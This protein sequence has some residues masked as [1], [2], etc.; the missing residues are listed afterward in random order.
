MKSA[1]AIF[2]QVVERPA[3]KLVFMR[4]KKA[5]HYY[6]YCEEQGCDRVDVV[7]GAL[8]KL[9]GRLYE[10]VGLWLPDALRP[11]GAGLYAMGV[12]V[13]ADFAGAVPDG[14][15]VMDLVPCSMLVFQGPP[16]AEEDEG[17][18]ITDLWERTADFQPEVYGYAWADHVAPK[19]QLAP[20]G[21]RG[22]IEARPVTRI[23]QGAV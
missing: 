5:T 22:Y 13:S 11:A 14:C 17:Q 16:F 10:P 21:F 2:V 7:W 3:R 9:P 6:E 19:V 18:A 12:E 1:K 15:E 23:G 8:E 4:G 20:M